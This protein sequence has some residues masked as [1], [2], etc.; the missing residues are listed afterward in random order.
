MPRLN[1]ELIY[2]GFLLGLLNKIYDKQFRLFGTNLRWGTILTS[3]VFGALHGFQLIGNYQIQVD[4]VNIFLTGS[5]GFL[6]ALIKER[7]GRL[8][9]PV[10]AHSTLDFFHFNLE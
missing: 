3:I 6:F 1:E 10:I 8:V 7:S 4:F 5:Y 9:F 2:R